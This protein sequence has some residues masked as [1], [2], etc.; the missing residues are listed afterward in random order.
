MHKRSYLNVKKE[1]IELC[2]KD[3]KFIKLGGIEGNEYYISNYGRL[4][5][6]VNSNG[7]KILKGS[8]KRLKGKIL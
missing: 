5:S 8:D 7:F 4:L 1:N 2:A 6:K 3:E